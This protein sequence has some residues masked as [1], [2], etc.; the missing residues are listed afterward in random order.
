MW[1]NGTGGFVING[2]SA[3][4]QAGRSVSAAGDVNGDGFDDL[5]VGARND[6]PNGDTTDN[7]GASF[8]VFGGDFQNVATDVG[9]TGA[10]TLTGTADAEVIFAGPGDDTIDG[11]GG[12]DRLSGAQGAD[13]FVV[14]DLAGTATIIDF[15]GGT[16]RVGDEG[17]Q[18]D[19]SA[20]GFADFAAFEAAATPTGPGG[21]R[22]ADHSGYGYIRGA[23][24]CRA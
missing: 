3:D 8:V 16:G 22:H 15:D 19:L 23:G 14:R 9:T 6:D 5:I 10:D 2:V 20:F 17:D 7:S 1:K 4:D 18:L 24:K 13:T 11:G 21:R 12:A